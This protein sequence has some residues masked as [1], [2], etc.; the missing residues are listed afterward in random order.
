MAFA[1]VADGVFIGRLLG[2]LAGFV[3]GWINHS[4][5]ESNFDMI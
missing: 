5:Q 4:W 1:A 2:G 3:G